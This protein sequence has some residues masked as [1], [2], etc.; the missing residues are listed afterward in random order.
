MLSTPKIRFSAWVRW[1]DRAQ[2]MN[3]SPCMGIC[4]WAHFSKRPSRGSRPFP[5]LPRQL[6]YVG[7]ANGLNVRPLSGPHH[8]LKH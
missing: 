3:G 1:H 8:R 7:E 5:D 4:A 2:L 6:I